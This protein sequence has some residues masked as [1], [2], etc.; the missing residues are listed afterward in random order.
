MTQEF[1]AAVIDTILPG[2]PSAGAGGRTVPSG[3]QAGVRIDTGQPAVSVALQSIIEQSGGSEA[4]IRADEGQRIAVLEAVEREH[5]AEFRGL[6]IALLQD[7]YEVEAVLIALGASAEPP[8]PGGR[9]VP[10][11]ELPILDML[12]KIRR[13]GPLWRPDG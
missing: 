9:P 5:A 8:Q 2:D 6:V 1:L 7:Y 10:P 11:T 4:F 13:R 12:D 3:S